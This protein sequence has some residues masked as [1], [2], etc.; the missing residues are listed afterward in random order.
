MFLSTARILVKEGRVAMR[1]AESLWTVRADFVTLRAAAPRPAEEGAVSSI[2][3][4]R[5]HVMG[6]NASSSPPETRWQMA[7]AMDG[8]VSLREPRIL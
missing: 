7:T 4:R 5:L 1:I 6:A 3:L 2:T 8:A